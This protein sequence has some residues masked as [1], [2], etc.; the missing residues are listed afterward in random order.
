[1]GVLTLVVQ[2]ED[3]LWT[4]PSVAQTCRLLSVDLPINILWNSR[5]LFRGSADARRDGRASP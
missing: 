1:V 5:C 3:L 4:L 2:G